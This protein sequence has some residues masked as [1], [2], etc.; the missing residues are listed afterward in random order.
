MGVD[1]APDEVAYRCNLV[2]VGTDGAGP[3]TMVDFAAGHVTSEQS[4]VIVAALDAALGN[5]RDGVRFHPGV[6]YRHLCVV[7]RGLGD[8]E[9]VPPHDLTGRPIVLPSGPAAAKLTALD[10]RVEAGRRGGRRRGRFGRDAD[11]ALGSGHA[12]AAAR[13]RRAPRRHRSAVVGGR[14]RARARRALRHRGARRP[15][16]DRGV[17]QRLRA[18]SATP[19][20]RRSPT[21]TSSCC[22]SRRPT[23]PGTRARSTRRS[24]RSNGGTPTSSGRWS[25]PSATSRTASSCCPTTRR[26][27]R[28]APTRPIRCRTSSS[29]PTRPVRAA[30]TPSAASPAARRCPAHDLMARLLALTARGGCRRPRAGSTVAAPPV[31]SSPNPG[32]RSR[33]QVVP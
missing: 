30:S 22:T 16:R 6:E 3:D 20:S 31:D 14:P 7:P 24:R 1:L 12:P 19:R 28:R 23:R 15:R 10:G 4:H 2:T 8:A 33:F 27:A 13:L 21:A 25:T 32:R 17:R 5:G 18:R 9:C 26:R 29:T 11:L